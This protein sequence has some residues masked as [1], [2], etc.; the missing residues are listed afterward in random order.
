MQS[1]ALSIVADPQ[2]AISLADIPTAVVTTDFLIRVERLL[3]P[4]FALLPLSLDT[5]EKLSQ[6]FYSYFTLLGLPL[7]AAGLIL[8][9]RTF[10][11]LVSVHGDSMLPNLQE[12]DRVL[13]L[14]NWPVRWLRKGQIVVGKLPHYRLPN[15]PNLIKTVHEANS[16]LFIKRVVGLPGDQLLTHISDVQEEFRSHL[17]EK[18][19]KNETRTWFVPPHHYF[20]K[21]DSAGADSC[22]WGPLASQSLVGVVFYSLQNQNA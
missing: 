1:S 19:D 12:G 17:A 3:P 14:R 22:L 21:S 8:F 16:V 13:V 18:H 20:V 4:P 2:V 10:L 9:F 7:C 5:K 15:E 11:L 6:M